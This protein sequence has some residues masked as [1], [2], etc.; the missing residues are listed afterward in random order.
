MSLQVADDFSNYQLSKLMRRSKLNQKL[1]DV[2]K[3]LKSSETA[4]VGLSQGSQVCDVE[5]SRIMSSDSAHYILVRGVDMESSSQDEAESQ[6]SVEGGAEER[7][8]GGGG[9]GDGRGV[10]TSEQVGRREE[11]EKEEEREGKKVKEKEE[12][13]K[14]GRAPV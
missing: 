5:T 12:R 7:G 10:G 11:E 3:V 14:I 8:R 9:E 6:G 1:E 4:V 2:R 13:R